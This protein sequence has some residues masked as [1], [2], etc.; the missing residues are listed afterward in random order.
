MKRLVGSCIFKSKYHDFYVN[1]TIFIPLQANI[2]T[3]DHLKETLS[4]QLLEDDCDKL[5]NFFALPKHQTD[6]I[7]G[8]DEKAENLLFVLEEKGVIAPTNMHTLATAFLEL[9]INPSCFQ[10]VDFYQRTRSKKSYS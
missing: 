8:S 5:R 3:F 1:I 9:N 6:A 10:L 7:I 2:F 4:S